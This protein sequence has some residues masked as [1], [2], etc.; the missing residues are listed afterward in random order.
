MLQ[1]RKLSH[2]NTDNILGS[3]IGFSK[4]LKVFGMLWCLGLQ[5]RGSFEYRLYVSYNC[6]LGAIL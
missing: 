5:I 4:I 3:S 2:F 1:Y 6:I